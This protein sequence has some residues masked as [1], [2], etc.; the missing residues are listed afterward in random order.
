LIGIIVTTRR[1]SRQTAPAAPGAAG[2]DPAV[3]AR[4]D[5]E[6]RNLD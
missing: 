5:D 6:L 1:W 4:L 3:S 2:F